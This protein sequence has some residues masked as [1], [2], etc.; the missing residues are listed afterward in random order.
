M[1]HE[2]SLRFFALFICLV[3]MGTVVSSSMADTTS[4][5]ITTQVTAGQGWID[6]VESSTAVPVGT[7]KHFRL[8]PARGQMISDV[9]ID[10]QSIGP[11]MYATIPLVTSNHTVSVSFEPFDQVKASNISTKLNNDARILLI[12][13]SQSIQKIKTYLDGQSAA[14]GGLGFNVTIGTQ[15]ISQDLLW[16][17]YI[18][19]TGPGSKNDLLNKIAEGWDYIV[20]LDL[21]DYPALL[22][23]LHFEGIRLIY[24]R[25]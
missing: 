1:K 15:A 16:E 13:E 3:V 11:M 9:Q 21:Y 20:P 8:K 18:N 2:T 7:T 17:Y 19:R 6:T 10:G 24:N 5:T 14:D 23:E 22:P 12:G 25:A 4:Y